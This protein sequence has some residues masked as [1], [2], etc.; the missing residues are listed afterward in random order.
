MYE[1]LQPIIDFQNNIISM[2]DLVKALGIECDFLDI[3]DKE[4][5]KYKENN[6]PINSRFEILDL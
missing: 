4:V 2:K 5:E 1:Y 3:I 6:G